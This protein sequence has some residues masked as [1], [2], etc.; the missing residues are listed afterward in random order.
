M[1]KKEKVAI[2]VLAGLAV[3][4]AVVYLFTSEKGN[5]IRKKAVKRGKELLDEFELIKQ[6]NCKEHAKEAVA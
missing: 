3:S 4:A 6:M 5:E 1:K 2:A